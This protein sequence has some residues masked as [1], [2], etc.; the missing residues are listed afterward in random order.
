M[1]MEEKNGYRWQH[2]EKAQHHRLQGAHKEHKIKPDKG[3]Q[4]YSNRKH[5][6]RVRTNE[7]TGQWLR[8]IGKLSFLAGKKGKFG[9]RVEKTEST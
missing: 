4:A 9:T 6:T 7:S 8:R 3:H 5:R 2:E 1:F